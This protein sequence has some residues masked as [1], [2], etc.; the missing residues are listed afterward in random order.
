MLL[1]IDT[2]SVKTIVADDWCNSLVSLSVSLKLNDI[3][4][5]SISSCKCVTK[6]IHEYNSMTV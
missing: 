5:S 3:D 6:A 2:N 4:N 1:A